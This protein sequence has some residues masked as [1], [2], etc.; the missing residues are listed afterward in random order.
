VDRPLPSSARHRLRL[1]R[2]ATIAGPIA[3]FVAILVLLPG[4]IRPTLSRSR[5][6]T[7]VVTIGAVDQVI[8][9]SGTVV[10][11]IERIISSPVD[12]RLLHVLERPGA[13]LKAGDPIVE[14]DTSESQL[15]YQ[16]LLTD[17]AIS[18][19]QRQQATLA[20]EKTLADLDA[21]IERKRLEA[22]SLDEKAANQRRLLAGGLV[23]QQNVRES[24]LA[25][26]QARIELAQL[27]Q[28]RTLTQRSTDLQAAGLELQ[29][30]ALTRSATD[31]RRVLRLA[32]ARSDR[33]GVL[34]SV[35]TQEG[36][37]VRRGDVIAR[38]ADLRSFRVDGSIPDSRSTQLRAGMRVSV[39]AG[40]AS[41]PGRITQ[42][43]PSVDNGTVRFAVA[44]DEPSHPVLRPNLTVDTSI[45]T[46]HHERTLALTQGPYTDNTG[47]RGQVFV[48]RG[49][50][51]YRTNVTFGLRGY[52]D[53]EVT[54]GLRAG[55]EV[56]ISDM[57]DYLHL[58]EIGIR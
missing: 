58:K 25:A 30:T 36:A 11:E 22:Q 34:T 29:R 45:V 7:A 1:R 38:V 9:A 52:D 27:R 28:E 41:L 14:L 10:P 39:H 8:T 5:I 23:S 21:R 32:T 4:W 24:D 43:F 51:A 56:V 13:T 48:V 57:K 50:R 20:L 49:D 54:S 55:D 18:D 6:R 47:A 16:R 15:A 2:I 53:L 33:D 42:V 26:A 35:L 37:L 46:D 44:L 19:N 31:A 3:A 17:V 12:A 40:D